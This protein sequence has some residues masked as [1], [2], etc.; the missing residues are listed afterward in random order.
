LKLSKSVAA[1]NLL[2]FKQYNDCEV[3]LLPVPKSLSYYLF[4]KNVKDHSWFRELLW[5]LSSSQETSLRWLLN[6]L[7]KLHN[8]EFITAAE[9]AG[10]SLNGKVIDAE[11]AAAMWEEANINCWY[12]RSCDALLE[13]GW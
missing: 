6:S 10:L 13:L 1:G 4:K 11:S 8:E 5:A 3:T 12:K 7:S 9:E 2:N